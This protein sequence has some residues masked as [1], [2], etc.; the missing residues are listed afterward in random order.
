MK[1]YFFYFFHLLS[2]LFKYLL[3]LLAVGL[4]F[5]GII[6]AL[7]YQDLKQT[8]RT[9]WEGKNYLNAALGAAKNQEWSRALE[10]AQEAQKNFSS[11]LNNLE[12]IRRQP[13]VGKITIFQ[14]AVNDLEYLLKT[15]EILSRSAARSALLAGKLQEIRSGAVSPNFSKWSENDKAKLLKLLYESEPE[16]NGLRA[17]LDLAIL[18]L[19]KIHRLGILWP[20]YGRISDIRQ[21]LIESSAIMSRSV[22]LIKLLPLLAG[23]P[24]TS[25]FLIV[26]QNN[27]ELRPTGGFIG[28]YGLLSCSQGE[29]KTL[30]T[31]DSYHLDMPALDKWRLEPP[32]PLKKYL[33]VE[34]W[35]LRDA[36]WSPDW[37]SAAKQI[38]TIY[39]G[40]SRAIGQSAPDFK[41]VI[42]IT[43][44]LIADLLR[45]V[46]PISV[47]ETTYNAD[48]FQPLLQYNVEV[49][50]KEQNI[51]SWDR[52]EVINDLLDELKE[53]LFSLPSSRWTELLGILDQNVAAKNIQI[54]LH[55]PESQRLVINFGAGGEIKS[56]T[57]DYLMVV[58]ANLGAFKSDAVIKKNISYDFSYQG[59]K[60]IAT[61]KLDYQHEGDFDWR[62]TRYRSYT[63]VYVPSG[64]K[65]ISLNGISKEAAD[66]KINEESD[67]NKTSFGFFWVIE[68]GS[69][70]QLILK[71]E[72]PQ[73]IKTVSEENG[74]YTFYWQKQAG[75]RVKAQATID[76][77]SQK[78]S[79]QGD[80][81][82]D[83]V[84]TLRLNRQKSAD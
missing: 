8:I 1:K 45:L 3:L 34:N 47:G 2:R 26:L 82:T 7:S 52:K 35:Y 27:D 24:E 80:L 21:E 79:W 51:S 61:L 60:I 25:D 68:P 22:P 66:L 59:E 14:T 57:A 53:R 63:R 10:D 49:A 70:K 81:R 29:I 41:G 15:A 5:L 9:G 67:L 37:P 74:I 16:L 42:A 12:Q 62:T 56:E 50:Y 6:F 54:Y 78:A 17:N 20:I 65:F 73:K 36:N 11:A 83:Q 72:L 43:P 55:D 77:R 4:I 76:Y 58:D 28:V 64:S 38:E 46:G 75:S 84:I 30:S 40:E 48:N 23:Y 32:A 18:N 69:Q 33:K 39:K 44:D 31:S 19:D 71:Y 13:V